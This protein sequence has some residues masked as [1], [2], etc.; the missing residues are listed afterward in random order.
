MMNQLHRQRFIL[1]MELKN[2]LEKA[3]VQ[4]KQHEEY[5]E[6]LEENAEKKKQARIV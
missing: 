4:R 5:Q 3:T 6:Q 1:M 2:N